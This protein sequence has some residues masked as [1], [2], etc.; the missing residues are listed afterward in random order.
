[1]PSVPLLL[2]LGFFSLGLLIALRWSKRRSLWTATVVGAALL[3]LVL[4]STLGGIAPA[5]WSRLLLFCALLVVGGVALEYSPKHILLRPQF[6]EAQ[7]RAVA[8]AHTVVDV[9]GWL[10]HLNAEVEKLANLTNTVALNTRLLEQVWFFRE[11]SRSELVSA[12][13]QQAVHRHRAILIDF[14]A[15]TP[16]D[17]VWETSERCLALLN[18]LSEALGTIESR[19]ATK[20]VWLMTSDSILL[21]LTALFLSLSGASR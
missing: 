10:S 18:G 19:W 6:D 9:I 3:P 8:N 16:R 12:A 21:A 14:L 13:L 17:E 5:T 4:R 1:M 15:C 11:R 2:A 20:T 7:L